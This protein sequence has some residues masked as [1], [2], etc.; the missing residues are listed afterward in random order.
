LC[1]YICP[2]SPSF[3]ISFF[4]GGEVVPYVWGRFHISE[5][6]EIREKGAKSLFC[7]HAFGNVHPAINRYYIQDI[8]YGYMFL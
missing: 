1:T 5:Q 7:L 3:I 6:C 4:S 2:F 8:V